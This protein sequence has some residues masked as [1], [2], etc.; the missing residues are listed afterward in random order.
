MGVNV[1]KMM[2][3]PPRMSRRI[4]TAN[5]WNTLEFILVIKSLLAISSLC[6]SLTTGPAFPH[7]P[8]YFVPKPFLLFFDDLLQVCNLAC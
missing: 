6:N 8:T 3:E 7:N 5:C 2:D 1:G 4:K